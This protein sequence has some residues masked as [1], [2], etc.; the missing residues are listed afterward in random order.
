VS[1]GRETDLLGLAA[2]LRLRTRREPERPGEILRSCLDPS[3]AAEAFGW[4]A[5]VSLD[6]GL[7]GT[8]EAA[9]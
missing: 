3:R 8:L 6:E 7:Q 4:R 2:A 9:A 5:A 1:T